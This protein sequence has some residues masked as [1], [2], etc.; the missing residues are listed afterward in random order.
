MVT[1]A[2]LSLSTTAQ[3]QAQS[4]DAREIV[5]DFEDSASDAEV[6]DAAREAG[7]ELSPNSFLAPRDRVLRGSVS[8]SRMGAVL[9]RL[10]ARSSVRAADENIVMRATWTPNDPQLGDQWGMARVHAT[11]AWDTTCGRGVTVAVVDT[12]VACENHGE[13]TRLMDLSGTRCTLGYN[14][15]TDDAHANDD[16]GHGTHVAGTIAQTTNNGFGVAGLAHCATI[17]PVKVLD[18]RGRGTLADVAEGIRFAADAGAQVINLSLGGGR[19]VKVLEEAVAYAR[20]RGAVVVCAAGNN[21]R[22]VESPAAEPGAFA[23]SA[24]GPAADD[25]AYFSSRGP[26]VD[27]AAPGVNILQQTICNRGRERCEQFAAWSGTSMAAP[28]VAGAAALLV[29]VGV[30]DPDAIE[31]T[32]RGAAARP[33]NGS[34]DKELYGAGVL[35]AAAAVRRAV[36][37]SALF[38]G[39]ALAV[40]ATLTFARIRMRGG[41]LANPLAWAPLAFLTGVGL[42]F[43]PT[44]VA[45]VTP[46]IDLLSRPLGDWSQ[47]LGVGVHKWLPFANAAIPMLLVGLGFSRPALRAPI[48]GVALGTAAYLLGTLA[49]GYHRAPLGSIAGFLWFAVNSLVCLWIARIGLDRESEKG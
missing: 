37:T 35:D 49:T 4:P 13:F 2:L 47:L 41:K 24:I 5:V 20:S 8:A 12:G 19:R 9:E 38:R 44:Y 40:L 23:V 10:R 31:R 27:I 26:E 16:Q 30:T 6:R 15:V 22:Y 36:D 32:L 39:I 45:R 18:E 33:E 29:S 1:G 28:H 48:G 34:T 25:L 3:A 46:G 21:G 42:W 17:M 11:S 43:L 7:V 14:F